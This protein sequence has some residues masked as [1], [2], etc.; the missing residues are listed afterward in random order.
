MAI[1]EQNGVEVGFVRVVDHDLVPGVWPDM[2]EHGAAADERPTLYERVR[3]AD[4]LVLGVAAS[5]VAAE[6]D[7]AGR[8]LGGGFVGIGPTRNLKDTDV[9]LVARHKVCG[10]DF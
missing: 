7:R 6:F 1:M 4:I 10:K 8:V 3:E 9:V 2:R 5:A